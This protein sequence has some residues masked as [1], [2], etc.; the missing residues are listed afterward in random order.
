MTRVAARKAAILSFVKCVALRI[1]KHERHSYDADM[2]EHQE[3]GQT[4]CHIVT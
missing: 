4:R 3:T 2:H 1:P